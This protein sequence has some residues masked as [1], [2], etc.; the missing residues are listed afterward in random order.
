MRFGLS[1]GPTAGLG[2][3]P[4]RRAPTASQSSGACPRIADRQGGWDGAPDRRRAGA[5]RI[6]D[7]RVAVA[8]RC[9]RTV[10]TLPVVTVRLFAGTDVAAGAGGRGS[11]GRVR[12]RGALDTP[13]VC[14]AWQAR[15]TNGASARWGPRRAA[16]RGSG[17]T[18]PRGQGTRATVHLGSGCPS[19][20]RSSGG[21]AAGGAQSAIS[22]G[23]R[24]DA[25]AGFRAVARAGCVVGRADRGARRQ[26]GAVVAGRCPVVPRS[27]FGSVGRRSRRRAKSFLGLPHA[28][29]AASSATA[30]WSCKKGFSS[31]AG[32]KR[33]LNQSNLPGWTVPGL[34]GHGAQPG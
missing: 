32:S 10:G 34:V 33:S 9:G 21:A 17:V 7:P 30:A 23:R 4:P 13:G 31:V 20:W 16:Q 24:P 27:A 14:S 22:P 2:G 3:S 11:G 8:V 28:F 19:C 12:W 5:D 15:R 18:A 29:A 1:E 25:A 26:A 6:V